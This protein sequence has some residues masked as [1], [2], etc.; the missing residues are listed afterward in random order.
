MNPSPHTHLA[1]APLDR[2]EQPLAFLWQGRWLILGTAL[3]GAAIGLTYA[4]V[5]GTVWRAQSVI[6]VARTSP[7]DLGTTAAGAQFLPRN[8]ANTQA[9][10]LRSTPVLDAALARPG[11]RDNPVLGEPGDELS[12][13]KRNLHVA[14][15]N[16]DDLIT[17]TLDSPLREEACDVVNA[18]VDSY[19]AIQAGNERGTNAAVLERLSVEL[20]RCEDDLQARQDEL[21]EFM[22]AN[23][24]VRLHTDTDVGADQ[25]RQLHAAL[26]EA[27][28]EALEA[29][30]TWQSARQIAHDPELLRQ[31]PLLASGQV[32]GT[33]GQ[34]ADAKQLE[35]L[36]ALRLQL[37]AD[38]TANTAARFRELQAR[39]LQLLS[40]VAPEHPAVAEIDRDLDLLRSRALNDDP[41]AGLQRTIDELERTASE[42]E[43]RFAAAYVQ[44]LEGRYLGAV[45]R[46]DDLRAEITAREGQLVALEPKQAECRLLETKVERSRKLAELLYQRISELDVEA[47]ATD[48][49]AAAMDSLIF[50]Y[51]TP[52]GA[53][54]AS[55][56]SAVAFIATLLGAVLGALAA[57]IKVLIDQKVRTADDVGALLPVLAAIPRVEPSPDGAVGTWKLRPEF[58][59][60]LRSLRLALCSSA[61][62]ARS[63]IYQ[64]ASPEAEDGKS[65]VAAGLGIAMAQAGQRTLIVDADFYRP[66]QSNLFGIAGGAGLSQLLENGGPRP[67]PVETEVEGL[68]VLPSGPLPP[69]LDGLLVR[70]R[71]EA[72]L[73][74]LAREF[75]CVIIDSPPLLMNI[76]GRALAT[77]CEET[78]L[79]LRSG[80]TTRK[81]AAAALAA[82]VSVGGRVSG[83]VL[84]RVPRADIPGSNSRYEYGARRT[85]AA[86]ADSLVLAE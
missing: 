43:A 6:F 36:R 14:V 81:L 55:S 16:Q 25:L 77:L 3:L 23:P 47:Q 26:T 84:N 59:D 67:Q 71:P 18:V 57:W 61:R 22:Q 54:V 80:R 68:F 31:I 29:K 64:V 37:L 86:A 83:A 13:L 12:W 50:E 44:A 9:E 5:R 53:I 62:G 52:E 66:E 42:G 46:Q 7:L 41:T 19:R 58:A 70:S 65:L 45:A 48:P 33:S 60:A 15:G 35:A 78:L 27:G 10:L 82:V 20:D 72:V 21:I 4:A 17:V 8:Y 2:G 79:V 69:N 56:K 51:A 73:Q 24:G 11:I 34:S 1:P 49:Q 75:D 39:R 32:I 74:E 85:A 28:I 40:Q 76:D 30:A 38:V 63:K